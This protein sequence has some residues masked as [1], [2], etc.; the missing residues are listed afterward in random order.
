MVA[1]AQGTFFV[2]DGAVY[3]IWSVDNDVLARGSN[4]GTIYRSPATTIV[5]TG[6]LRGF[7]GRIGWGQRAVL[8]LDTGE[9]IVAL[10]GVWK[11]E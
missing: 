4:T 9:G 1:T 8:H 5:T 2:D 7:N 11:G 3:G 6:K 10:R